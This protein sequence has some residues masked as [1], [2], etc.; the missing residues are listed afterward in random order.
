MKVIKGGKI[1]S[2]DKK[3]Y[4]CIRDYLTMK[5]VFLLLSV[6]LISHI[7]YS[8]IT[9]TIKL[10]SFVSSFSDL[11]INKDASLLLIS[12][13]R[14]RRLSSDFS[15][16]V[17]LV[18]LNTKKKI[19]SYKYDR[20]YNVYDVIISQDNSKIACFADADAAMGSYHKILIWD[21]YSGELICEKKVKDYVRFLTFSPDSKYLAYDDVDKV[22]RV[23]DANNGKNYDKIELGFNDKFEFSSDWENIAHITDDSTISIWDVNSKMIKENIQCK[24]CFIEAF[25]FSCDGKYILCRSKQSIRLFNT[26]DGKMVVVKYL[27]PQDDD[28]YYDFGSVLNISNN[29]KFCFY[30]ILV[31]NKR[32]TSKYK[33]TSTIYLYDFDKKCAVD[34]IRASFGFVSENN[35][36]KGAILNG[37]SC[38]YIWDIT[39]STDKE[40]ISAF[41]KAK[42]GGIA[43]CNSYLSQYPDGAF[44]TDVKN[45][46]IKKEKAAYEKA[47]HGN[48]ND[49]DS[50][51]S[52][53]PNG[54]FVDEVK[55]EKINKEKVAYEK[56]INGNVYDCNNYLSTYPYG[57][58]VT[59]VKSYKTERELYEDAKGGDIVNCHKYISKYPNGIFVTDIKSII[60]NK[61]LLAYQK[62]QAGTVWDCDSYISQFPNGMYLSE[63]AKLK[64]E[65]TAYEKA[66]SGT[67]SDCTYY[68][69]QYP[70]GQYSNEIS[71]LKSQ[72]QQEIKDAEIQ[73]QQDIKTLAENT[74]YENAKNG[75]V[76]DCN[77]YLAKYPNG[78]YVSEVNTYKTEKQIEINR[79]NQLAINSNK[80]NWKM[81]NKLCKEISTGIICGTLNQWNENKSMAQIKIVSSPGGK[82][83]G[84]DLT[85]SNLIWVSATGKDWHICFEDEISKSVAN[86]K[87]DAR[88]SSTNTY[89]MYNVGDFIYYCQSSHDHQGWMYTRR[90]FTAIIKGVIEEM[91]TDKTRAKVK[92]ITC[93]ECNSFG[94]YDGQSVYIGAYIWVNLYGWTKSPCD[95]K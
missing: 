20:E 65:K 94:T 22:I 44:V 42:N 4:S 66:K 53:F 26:N 37:N 13:G 75:S 78:R 84:E 76:S 21:R 3:S 46:M 79:Y 51:L 36:G 14:D 92:I 62:A 57:K 80:A 38:V 17:V 7:S 27:I 74:A 61:D 11:N 85:K 73:R 60:N 34:S 86:D 2:F 15:E 70:N 72:K 64:T 16:K 18:D 55:N 90:D 9:D 91:N 43:D 68:L 88:S 67:I 71:Q 32:E 8:Q 63:I 40:Q 93:K 87:S 48:N 23:I 10:S 29:N 49:C 47:I 25:K 54:E 12:G 35:N 5:F 39:R 58:Y 83:E 82:Y 56:A 33:K 41:E 19:S 6:V 77:N 81:G 95:N 31:E 28:H 69:S 59:E 24:G 50:Y 45:E 30:S 89:S 1:S 52:L